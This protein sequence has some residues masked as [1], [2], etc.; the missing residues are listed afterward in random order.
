MSIDAEKIR[1]GRVGIVIIVMMLA[2]G[3]ST[4]PVQPIEP[5]AA[6]HNLKKPG[7]SG[8]EICYKHGCTVKK[9]VRLQSSDWKKIATIF[10]PASR[11]P[12]Q[13]RN[14]IAKSIQTMEIIVGEKT[15]LDS[16]LGGSFAGLL[17]A[18]QMD[19]VDE[20]L[21]TLTVFKLLQNAGFIRYHTMAGLA[22]RGFFLN[23][24]PHVACTIKDSTTNELYVVDSWFLDQGETVHVLPFMDWKNGWKPA[25]WNAW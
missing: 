1:Y 19:C 24:W 22:R 17:A 23:G 4:G 12:V 3:C 7:P 15:G 11:S 5:F 6:P 13:E 20:A 14:R 9:E 25:D 8:F 21:N 16:D 2:L 10:H 18:E